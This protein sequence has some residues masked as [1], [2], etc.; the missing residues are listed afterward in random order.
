MSSATAEP[1]GPLPGAVA[2]QQRPS[3][4]GDLALFHRGLADLCRAQVPLPKAL[5]VLQADLERGPL[6]REAAALADEVEEGVPLEEAYARR[7][8]RFS[9]VYRALVRAGMSGGGALPDVLDEIASHASA[10]AWIVDK[11]RRTM[12]YPLVATGFVVLLGAAILLFIGS[13]MGDLVVERGGE[14]PGAW[15]AWS[16]AMVV[17]LAL[18]GVLAFALLRRPLDE[19]V[20]PAGLAYKLPLIGH[21]RTYAAKATFAS[22]MAMLLRRSIPLPRALQ[23]TAAATDN[24]GIRARIERM[25]QAADEGQALSE[26]VEAGALISPSLSWFLEAARDDR[27]AAD[28]LDDIAAIYRQRLERTAERVAVIAAPVAQLMVGLVVLGFALTYMT[29]SFAVAPGMDR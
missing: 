16:G 7:E 27:A 25:A 12:A 2:G 14:A 5:R 9:P 8:R 6:A 19:G 28:A 29:A 17:G 15:Q 23:L 3:L 13:P 22:T 18:L 26:S 1:F 10:R 24:A 4:R 20:G 21:L 11:M